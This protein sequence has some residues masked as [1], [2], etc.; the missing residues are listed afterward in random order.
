MAT[1]KY[2]FLFFLLLVT[3]LLNG[4]GFFF[5]NGGRIFKYVT[6]PYDTNYNN[7]P[8]GSKK[9]QI[10]I[11]RFREPFSGLGITAEWDMDKINEVMKEAGMTQVYHMDIRILNIGTPLFELYKQKTLIIYGE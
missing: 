5:N 8:V 1:R 4:C 11:H 2:Y 7:T 10:K 3:L 6:I 9:C